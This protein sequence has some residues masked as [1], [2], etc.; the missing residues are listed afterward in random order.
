MQW[1]SNRLLWIIRFSD[2]N[3]RL[4]VSPVAPWFLPLTIKSCSGNRIWLNKCQPRGLW[5]DP[6]FPLVLYQ[7]SKTCMLKKKMS[8]TLQ[9]ISQE[10]GRYFCR[11]SVYSR[12]GNHRETH[13]SYYSWWCCPQYRYYHSAAVLRSTIHHNFLTTHNNICLT[14]EYRI[15][16]WLIFFRAVTDIDY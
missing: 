8:I 14:E 5:F 12:R 10:E 11:M 4:H 3:I 13:N 1:G 7:D 9:V 15:R 16:G 2:P 6:Q